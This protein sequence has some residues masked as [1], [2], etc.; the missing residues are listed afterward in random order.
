[1]LFRSAG[2]AANGGGTS[3]HALQAG[4]PAIGTVASG[5]LVDDQRSVARPA[6]NCAMGSYERTASE[7]AW[8]DVSIVVEDSPDPVTKSGILNYTILVTNNGSSEELKAL[9]ARLG[10]EYLERLPQIQLSPDILK[11]LDVAWARKNRLAPIRADNEK[12]VVAAS[13]PLNV[14]ATDELAY[15]LGKRVEVVVAPEG[16]ILNSLNLAFTESMYF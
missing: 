8:A 14:G 2:L 5:C 11:K 16:E 7:G 3:T 15:V 12:V 10:I 1:M 6:A 4:S 13:S 9:C